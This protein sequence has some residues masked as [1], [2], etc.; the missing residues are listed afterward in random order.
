[1]PSTSRE[2]IRLRLV[3][4]DDLE[5]LE[6][7]DN[8][9]LPLFAEVGIHTALAD[10]HPFVL[11]ELARW[12]AAIDAGR[13]WL[14]LNAD[15]VPLGFVVC[16]TVDGAPYVDQLSVRRAHMRRGVGRLL[17]HHAIAWSG[18]RPLWLTTYAHVPWNRPYY[19][20]MG[21]VVVHEGEHGPELRAILAEQRAALPAPSERV[22]M[23]RV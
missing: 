14:A 12:R 21:F 19:E 5:L 23:R 3:S 18:P 6:A 11:H 8:E 20:R 16:G 7:I 2:A 13:A 9:S 10:Q 17:L 15:E 1:M 22:A 4:P